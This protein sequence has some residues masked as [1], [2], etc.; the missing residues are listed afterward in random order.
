[1]NAACLYILKYILK[2]PNKLVGS[3]LVLQRTAK[4][5]NVHHSVTLRVYN[6]ALACY[7]L[8][9]LFK[10]RGLMSGSEELRTHTSPPLLTPCV[11]TDNKLGLMLG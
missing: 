8:K 4:I 5:N 2:V 11:S 10:K 1:M 9:Y 3:F 6:C 7:L